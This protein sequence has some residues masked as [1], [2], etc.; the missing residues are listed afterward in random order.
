MNNQTETP[1]PSQTPSTD[2]KMLA[3][4]KLHTKVGDKVST[5]YKA[6][7]F[8]LGNDTREQEKLITKLERELA[9]AIEHGKREF[10]KERAAFKNFHRL[11]CESV[12]CCHDESDWWRDQVSVAEFIRRTR[13]ELGEALRAKAELERPRDVSRLEEQLSEA[14]AAKD[15]AEAEIPVGTR[16]RF[17]KTL[18]EGPNE[19]HPG[20]TYAVKGDYGMITGHGCSEGFM[21]KWDGWLTADFGAKLGEEFELAPK[22]W[23]SPE[24]AKELEQR[25][26]L[27]VEAIPFPE[28]TGENAMGMAW[29]ARN[30]EAN[31]GIT[32]EALALWCES[33]GL[34]MQAFKKAK[35]TLS[36]IG[37]KG[38]EQ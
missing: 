14:L 33:I 30:G 34:Q 20:R 28:I 2:A 4:E 8:A 27:L 11:I 29:H 38:G 17:L 3:I 25:E 6:A 7:F 19:D 31:A 18:E 24:R 12:D 1:T 23:L 21:V 32:L 10:G 37:S 15:K 9:T 22:D 16:I 26:K 5:C 13:H 35:E 36:T